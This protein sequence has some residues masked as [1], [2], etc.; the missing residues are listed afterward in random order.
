MMT[1]PEGAVTMGRETV[2]LTA[3]AARGVVDAQRVLRDYC[4]DAL[5]EKVEA[6][7][8]RQA[9]A[10][11]LEAMIW[12]RMAASHGADADAIMLAA[13][14]AHLSEFWGYDQE[15]QPLGNA[16]L[17]EAIAITE[18]VSANGH[19]GAGAILPTLGGCVAPHILQQ[20]KQIKEAVD[21]AC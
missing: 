10:H 15:G 4:L 14:L 2:A 13:C 7:D 8:L 16:M 17:S 18:R 9:Q 6:N 5:R 3:A 1:L 19:E 21:A 11:A 12:A 20:A